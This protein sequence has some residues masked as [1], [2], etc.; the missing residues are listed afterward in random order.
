VQVTGVAVNALGV[1]SALRE[2]IVTR[3]EVG[4]SAEAGDGDVPGLATFGLSTDARGGIEVS[5]IGFE[6]LENTHSIQAG[7]LRLHYWDEL[8]SPS[9]LALA[10]ELPIDAT[11]VPLSGH[12][13]SEVG[14]LLQVGSELM[15]VLT[16]AADRMSCEVERACYESGASAHQAGETVYPL[17]KHVAVLP[18]PVG[19]FGSAIASG[20]S[21]RLAL[22]A[23]RVAAA[24]LFFTNSRG[25][26]PATG[27]SYAMLL[28][29]GLR[30]MS[31]GQY[32]IQYDGVPAVMTSMAPPLVVDARTAVRDVRARMSVAPMGEPV[33]ARLMVNGA[34]YCEL[35]VPAG[36]RSS[37]VVSGWGRPPWNDG[38]ELR[39]DVV[40][41]GT[42][43]GSDP[44]RD[45]TVTVRV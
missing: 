5:G 22:P 19:F 16:V 1:E 14:D 38:D 30:T 41:V 42:S 25:D 39:V 33:V 15:R 6:S 31:G 34:A 43:G 12:L 36:S 3:F 17:L 8:S 26:G 21:Q 28:E 18:F 29:G 37:D 27:Q 10:A 23:A 20:Y 44:G 40:S 35:T 24:E 4:G 11:S 32:T 7:T 13:D 2:A 9:L 45:L